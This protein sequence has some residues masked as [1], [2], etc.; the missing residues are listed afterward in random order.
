MIIT[1]QRNVN[2]PQFTSRN[3]NAR[4]PE[5]MGIGTSIVQVL[6]NDDDDGVNIKSF[7]ILF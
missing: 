2:P 4:I 3:F 7:V 6:A 1:V 5:T